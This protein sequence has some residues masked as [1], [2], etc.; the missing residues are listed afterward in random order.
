VI[1]YLWTVAVYG[2]GPPGTL[3]PI[4]LYV[5]LPL[6]ALIAL[7]LPNLP[8]VMGPA[9]PGL[10]TPGYPEQEVPAIHRWVDSPRWKPVMIWSVI[11]ALIGSLCLLKLNDV[12]E[13]IYFQF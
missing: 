7:A 2:A 8:R 11:V 1:D 13:F 5:V 3:N 10:P 6:A 9:W 12:S 4:V